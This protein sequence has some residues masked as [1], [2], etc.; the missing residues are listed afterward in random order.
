MQDWH[1]KFTKFGISSMIMTSDTDT[2]DYQ[3]YE[4]FSIILTTP[5]KWDSV[6]RKWRESLSFVGNIKLM[7]IDEVHLLNE[8]GRGAILEVIVTRMKIINNLINKQDGSKDLVRFMAVSATIPNIEDIAE[9]LGNQNEPAV[10][11]T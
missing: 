2:F 8:E 5:E 3:N 9:W 6:T 11:Y 10:C 4:K 7:M 1:L